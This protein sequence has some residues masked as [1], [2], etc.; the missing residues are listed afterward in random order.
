MGKPFL[1]CALVMAELALGCGDGGRAAVS[2]RVTL[3]G[4]PLQEGSITFVPA[5]GNPGPTAG[6]AIRDGKYRLDSRN[7]PAV[8]KNRVEIRSVVRTGRRIPDPRMPRLTIDETRSVVP[9]RY[10]AESDLV[11]D[12]ASGSNTFDFE[13]HSH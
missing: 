13:L 8:G 6:G 12:I 11:R 1:A 9:K 3:D 10:N 7:G 5:D 2:G 4:E